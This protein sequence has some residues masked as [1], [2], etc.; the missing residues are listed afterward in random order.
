[1]HHQT[2]EKPPF[3]Q[4]SAG[5]QFFQLVRTN[6]RTNFPHFL[7]TDNTILRGKFWNP[8][9]KMFL[10]NFL[11]RYPLVS[12]IWT[13]MSFMSP[14]PPGADFPEAWLVSPSLLIVFPFL[15]RLK[16]F[17]TRN[18]ASLGAEKYHFSFFQQS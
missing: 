10:H 1:M 16:L 9:S 14:A 13:C 2:R 17:S 18:S 12:Y 15:I 4:L 6:P 5:F 7:F 8:N 11:L 3:S